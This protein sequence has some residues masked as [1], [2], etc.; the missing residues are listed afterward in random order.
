M[1]PLGYPRVA[2]GGGEAHAE[3][4]SGHSLGHPISDGFDDP[5]TKIFGVGFHG[6]HDRPRR[7]SGSTVMVF[8]VGFSARSDALGGL[9]NSIFPGLYLP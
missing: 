1:P 6:F 3:Q 4:L 9:A 5:E 8:A 2:R 7:P